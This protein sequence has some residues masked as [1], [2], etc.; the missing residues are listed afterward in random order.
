M[1]LNLIHNDILPRA[2]FHVL[3]LI[4][5]WPI[6]DPALA[7]I[8][9]IVFALIFQNPFQDIAE[10]LPKKLLPLCMIGLG[11]GM[12][13]MTVLHVGASG[14]VYTAISI[15]LTISLGLI[16]MRALK[17]EREAGML[18][19]IGTAICGGSAI[20]AIAPVLNARSGAIAVSL[21]VVFVLNATAL[22]IFPPIGEAL[23][24][25]QHAFGLWSA[26]AIHDTSSVV[27]AGLKYGEEALQTGTAVK[28]ARALWIVPLVFAVQAV[29]VSPTNQTDGQVKRKYPWFI[30]GFLV[31][32]AIVTF[33][34]V[35]QSAGEW[36][37]FI[38]RRGLV[39]TLF[40]IGAN[41]HMNV[42]KSV[43]LRPFI[44]GALL[45]AFV[46]IVSL[47]AIMSGL[48]G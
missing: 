9:G 36:I 8:M 23:N 5:L 2:L 40:L 45:W 4:C 19:T 12:N 32:A 43:G 7:L 31:L 1:P 13:L 20:A 21:A 24:M 11:G 26:L 48:I 37:A 28:L 22:L 16:M 38:A 44:M 42:L 27:G 47:A 25:D 41:I 3:A 15:A 10:K 18:I 14:F 29:Y 6:I 33:V 39:L 17:V 30:F 35:L 34:P 46:S